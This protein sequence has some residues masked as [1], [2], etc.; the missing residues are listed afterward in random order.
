MWRD[1]Q[2]DVRSFADSDSVIEFR[3][4]QLGIGDVSWGNVGI[5]AHDVFYL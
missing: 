2:W 5:W 4:L 1:C 3:V